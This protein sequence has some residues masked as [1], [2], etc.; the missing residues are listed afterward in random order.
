VSNTPMFLDALQPFAPGF[1]L[2]PEEEA[3]AYAPMFR[4][5]AIQQPI[6]AWFV[7]W[8]RCPETS[9]LPNPYEPWIEIWE[10]GGRSVSSTDS[11]GY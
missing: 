2:S 7:K 5:G 10:H 4:A 1:H 8:E 11:R 6:A 3:A 9:G